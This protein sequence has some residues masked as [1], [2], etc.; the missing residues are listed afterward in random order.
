MY[1][2]F[3]KELFIRGEQN[4]LRFVETG[5]SPD[6]IAFFIET[7]TFTIKIFSLHEQFR[8]ISFARDFFV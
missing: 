4:F 1:I 2:G 8:P 3:V 5:I 6:L 7:L